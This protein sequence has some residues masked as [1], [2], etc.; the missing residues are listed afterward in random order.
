MSYPTIDFL[1]LS[2]EDMIR[3]GVK[4]MVA[5]IDAMEVS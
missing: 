1:F 4:N 2:E 3:A 5:C